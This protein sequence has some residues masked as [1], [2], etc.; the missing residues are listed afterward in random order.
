[1][2]AAFTYP[3][4]GG[5]LVFVGL[6]AGDVTFNDPNFHRRELNVLASR[7]SLPADF[8]RIIGLVESGHVDTA[9]WITHRAPLA[10][11]PAQFARWTDPAAGVLKAMIAV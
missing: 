9:P 7:N 3:A 11:V 6:F 10:E 1:M 8:R 5:R 2:A 4:Q